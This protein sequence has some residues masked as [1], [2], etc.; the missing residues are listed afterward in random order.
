MDLRDM[1]WSTQHHGVSVLHNDGGT[2]TGKRGSDSESWLSVDEDIGGSQGSEYSLHRGS[3]L[4]SDFPL[5]SQVV[6]EIRRS[7]QEHS[8]LGWK[9]GEMDKRSDQEMEDDFMEAK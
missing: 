4:G 8:L 3:L 6:E 1:A 5:P 7:Q 2:G 9:Q